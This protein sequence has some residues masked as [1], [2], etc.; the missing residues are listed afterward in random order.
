MTDLAKRRTRENVEF[1][2][3]DFKKLSTERAEFF[4]TLPY[5]LEGVYSLKLSSY[6]LRFPADPINPIMLMELRGGNDNIVQTAYTDQQVQ[7]AYPIILNDDP[8]QQLFLGDDDSQ[9]I[10]ANN[11]GLTSLYRLHVRFRNLPNATLAVGSAAAQRGGAGTPNG[12]PTFTDCTIV[13]TVERTRHQGVVPAGRAL[14]ARIAKT[15]A[16]TSQRYPPDTADEDRPH[17][18][19]HAEKAAGMYSV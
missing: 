16:T 19:Y 14:Y 7:Y 4:V 18:R 11:D 6:T 9:Q 17:H 12:E 3:L 10:L 15:T 2:I 5:E 1:I 8:F 13:L